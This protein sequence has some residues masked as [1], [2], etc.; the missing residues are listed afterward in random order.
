MP[1]L[2]QLVDIPTVRAETGLSES[3][4]RTLFS[5]CD[6]IRPD[7]IRRVY[8]LRWQVDALLSVKEHRFSQSGGTR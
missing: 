4:V 8:A 7:G 5:K 1:E 2:P 6:V 3:E